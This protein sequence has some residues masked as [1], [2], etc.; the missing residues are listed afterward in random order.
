MTNMFY[1]VE[2]DTLVRD[3][4]SSAVLETDTTKLQQY[5]MLRRQKQEKEKTIED[6]MERINKLETL[7]E[8]IANGIDNT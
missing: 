2:N 5:R 4:N 8:R 6:L 7:M 3:S 1:K